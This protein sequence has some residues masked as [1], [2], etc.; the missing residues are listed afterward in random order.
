MARCRSLDIFSNVTLFSQGKLRDLKN[1][2]SLG[3][4]VY[5]VHLLGSGG[6]GSFGAIAFLESFDLLTHKD[7][8]GG[9][10][11]SDTLQI[12]GVL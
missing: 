2:F 11:Y 7:S 9:L 3:I 4:L 6:L 5:L 1:L 8:K 10:H 12:D